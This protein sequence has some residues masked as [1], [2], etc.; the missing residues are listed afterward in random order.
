MNEQEFVLPSLPS[1]NLSISML[2]HNT[3][4]IASKVVALSW[5]LPRTV[6]VVVAV[7]VAAAD[8]AMMVVVV[9]IAII[10]DTVTMPAGEV[11]HSISSLISCLET[12]LKLGAW[13]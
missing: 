6:V 2:I 11:S 12:N 9:D 8:I 1:L 5:S 3:I 13:R 7:V 4:A 10:A